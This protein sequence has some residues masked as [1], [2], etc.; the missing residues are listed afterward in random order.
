M[1]VRRELG[2]EAG[3]GLV[4]L[5]ELVGI[6]AGQWATLRGA[7]K[8]LKVTKERLKL[9]TSTNRVSNQKTLQKKPKH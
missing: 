8:E 9:D 7:E 2:D 4:D 5:G 6:P 3:E 1:H